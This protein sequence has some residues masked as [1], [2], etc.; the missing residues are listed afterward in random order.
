MKKW[1]T[2]LTCAACTFS[3]VNYADG[4]PANPTP[5]APL[6]TP[7]AAAQPA[8]EDDAAATPDAQTRKPVGKA[9][10]DGSKT[11]GSGAGK[12][13]LAGAAIAAGITALILVS[14]HSGHHK[15]KK[16]H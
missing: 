6:A 7:L 8:P 16:H 15:H 9:A 2:L 14:R 11:A 12:Y 4:V 1:I 13:V 5:D 3:S 10:D